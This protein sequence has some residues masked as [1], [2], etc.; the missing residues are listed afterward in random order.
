[1]SDK[2]WSQT[3]C[4]PTALRRADRALNRL[5]DEALRPANLN[6]T[7]Y[8]L[9]SAL[10]RAPAD[11]SFG[12]LARAQ[13]LDRTTLSRVLAP[14]ERDGLLTVEPGTDRRTKHINLTAAG[15]E[16]VA[17]ARPLWRAAQDIVVARMGTEWVDRLLDDLE[18]LVTTVRTDLP[19]DTST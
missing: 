2:P 16:R 11:I 9:L 8:S 15:R 6:I 17:E 3:T 4:A 5:Y 19:Q 7:Q 10:A 18:A 1:V 12:D 13:V 14:L